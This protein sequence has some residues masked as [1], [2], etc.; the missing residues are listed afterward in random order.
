MLRTALAAFLLALLAGSPLPAQED[1]PP[2]PAEIA[3]REHAARDESEAVDEAEAEAREDP[4]AAAEAAGRLPA[5]VVTHHEITVG[6]AS[7]AFQAVAGAITLVSPA[8]R[9][10]ADIAYLA[11]LAETD[12]PAARPVT[13]AVN[14]GPGAA[15]AYLHLGVLGPWRLPMDGATISP[16]QSIA[17]QENPETWLAFTDLVFVDPVGTGFSRLVEPDDRLRGRYLSIHGDIEAMADFVV[18]WLTQAGRLGSPKYFIGESYGGFR[19]PR[20][21]EALQTEH[22]VAL[23]GMTLLSPVLDFGWW[24]QPDHNPLPL[25]SLL[26]SL[27]AAGMERAGDY[28]AALLAEAEAYAGGPFVVDHLRGLADPAAVARMTERVAALTGLDPATVADHAG[29]LDMQSFARELWR[30]EGRIASPYDA[31]ITSLD[32]APERPHGRAPDPVLDAMTAPLTT[33]MIEH[34]RETLGW[35]PDR[36]YMLLNRGVN[37]AWNW[38]GGRGQPESVSALRRVLALDE[39]FR[40]LVV[41]GT[42]DL[43]TPYFASALILRQLPDFGGRVAE[44]AYRGGH[45]FYTRE[46]SRRGFRDDARALYGAR[47]D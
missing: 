38:G 29:R 3:G 36:R 7:L 5:P 8:G 18:R 22:G 34:Y 45:M 33:A 42:A 44:A 23:A 46:P 39:D 13:F 12:E 31:G 32:P 35:L 47:G 11:Y 1:P 43:V 14:G 17:L 9:E 2:T 19:G 10:E 37:R 41:H 30:A 27:A 25:A 24:Q 4:A 20:L 28:D 21:A 16:S 15:S 6:N 26:P 40:V